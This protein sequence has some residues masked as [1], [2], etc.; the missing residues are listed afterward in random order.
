MAAIAFLLFLVFLA[1]LF[2]LGRAAVFNVGTA[3]EILDV[4]KEASTWHQRLIVIAFRTPALLVNGFWTTFGALAVVG[5]VCLGSLF[6][7]DLLQIRPILLDFY[8]FVERLLDRLFGPVP[9]TAHVK[10]T[11]L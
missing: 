8:S 10:Q 3:R 9:P 4:Y 2:L 11:R 6:S 7:S 1:L 5:F